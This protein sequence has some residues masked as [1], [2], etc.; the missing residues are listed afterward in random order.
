MLSGL[1]DEL[2]KRLSTV[3]VTPRGVE[4]KPSSGWVLMDFGDII[5][6][7]FLEE[8]RNTYQLEKIWSD[9]AIVEIQRNEESGE[10]R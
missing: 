9:G 2:E 6:N 10:R 7:L 5:V 3:G 8:Q 1:Q 4:G